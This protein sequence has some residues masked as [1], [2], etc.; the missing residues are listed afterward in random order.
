MA[1]CEY[2]TPEGS[3]VDELEYANRVAEELL[4]KA[5]SGK[6]REHQYQRCAKWLDLIPGAGEYFRCLS[7][8]EY[9]DEQWEAWHLRAAWYNE[10]L[11]Q[12]NFSWEPGWQ[13][14]QWVK[15]G[16]EGRKVKRWR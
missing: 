15:K 11:A 2:H 13:A 9:S 6:I 5:R 3:E 12:V 8:E 4:F 16:K 1:L 14:R 7:M 10:H